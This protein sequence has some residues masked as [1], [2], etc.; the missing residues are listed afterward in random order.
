M[1]ET[2]T[3]ITGVRTVGIPVSDQDRAIAFYTG[4]LGLEK[5]LDVPFGDGRWVEVAPAGAVTSVALVRTHAGD[6]IGV[7]T[8]VRLDAVVGASS[9]IE[10]K[11]G[12]A[13][14][15]RY[16]QAVKATR[17]SA[18]PCKAGA[19]RRW[20]GRAGNRHEKLCTR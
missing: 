8:G 11:V 18:P 20:C 17:A 14:P 4:T 6:P 10:G 7:E 5:R 15:S 16:A 13:L 1:T 19:A 12:H 3:H 2:K 9:F